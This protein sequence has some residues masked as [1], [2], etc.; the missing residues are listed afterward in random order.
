MKPQ[1]KLLVLLLLGALAILV[2]AC[3]PCPTTYVVTKTEDTNDGFCRSWDCSLREAVLN[4]NTCPGPQ[5]I[6]IPPGGYT[7]TI[8]GIN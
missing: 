7:L 1:A 4:A 2:S 5:S 3:V 6:E 8:P